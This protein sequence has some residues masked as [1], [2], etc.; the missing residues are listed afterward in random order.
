[1]VVDLKPYKVLLNRLKDEI[2][3]LG[4][5]RNRMTGNYVHE[6]VYM[7]LLYSLEQESRVME[8]Q[9]K[10]INLYLK[11]IGLLQSRPK[12]AVIPIVGKALSVLFGTSRRC[13]NFPEETVGC[14][15]KSENNSSGG[16]RELI[17]IECH[18]N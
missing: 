12:R 2:F 18:K 10:E 15:K 13:K 14:G 9:W 1:M 5:A 7:K 8:Y 11:G 4:R 3:A 17:D 16:S 6:E